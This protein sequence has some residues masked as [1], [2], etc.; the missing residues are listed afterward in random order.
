MLYTCETDRLTLKIV[1]ED[2]APMVLALYEENK[3]FFECWEPKRPANF[4]TLNYQKASLSAEACQM[5]EGKLLRYWIFLK[6][7]PEEI[8]GSVCFQNFLT[9]PSF[10][11]SLG[12]KLSYKYNHCGYA[13]E[14]IQKAMKVI[15]QDYHMHRIEAFIMPGN[16]PSLRLIK[17]L[18]FIYEGISYSYA[19]VNGRWSDYKR[20]V[21]IDPAYHFSSTT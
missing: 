9:S 4:Y 8:I 17:R 5:S 1:N 3:P 6:N 19:C 21:L 18:H 20:Y 15:W 13:Y 14:S 11:C 10:S 12:Y 7:S 2:A 16:V